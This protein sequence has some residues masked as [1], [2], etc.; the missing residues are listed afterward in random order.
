MRGIK[1]LTT[2][3]VLVILVTIIVISSLHYFK[4]TAPETI[5]IA[6]PASR[7]CLDHGGKLDLRETNKGTEGICILPGGNIECEE[8]S[9]LRGSCPIRAKNETGTHYCRPEEKKVDICHH[10]YQL[11]CGFDE[12]N[13]MKEFSN[14]CFACQDKD[15]IFWK[16][17]SCE[18]LINSEK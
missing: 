12:D 5:K 6:N 10:V 18:E 4:T 13:N 1:P 8:W 7:Y 15:I 17:G 9:F 14:G 2:V 3:I 11:V 16:T